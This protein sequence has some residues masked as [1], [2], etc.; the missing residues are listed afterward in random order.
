MGSVAILA[1]SPSTRSCSW[2]AGRRVSSAAISTLM[3]CS[4]VSLS[5]ILA[6][7]VVLPEPCSPTIITA[8]GGA[9][10]IFSSAV[11]AP[12]IATKRS[13]TT[14]MTICAGATLRST[15]APLASRC[16]ASISDLTTGSATSASRSATRTSRSTAVTSASESAP[17]FLRRVK[18]SPSRSVRDSNIA[19]PFGRQNASARKVAGWPSRHLGA[20]A[21]PHN[22]C[23]EP[24]PEDGAPSSAPRGTKAGPLEKQNGP[25]ICD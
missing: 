14:L 3:P 5:A 15:S 17:R 13:Y 22:R 18:I 9:A 6:L 25:S 24:T 2:A 1:C 21:W 23:P 7:V 20:R 16:T 11:S 10:A 12:S 8:A 19:P 4:L